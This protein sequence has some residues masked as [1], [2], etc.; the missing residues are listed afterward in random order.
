MNLNICHLVGRVTKQ[1]ES[2]A[3]PSGTTVVKFGLA[4]NHTFKD[5]NG[6]QQKTAQFHNLVAFGKVAEIIA[7]FVVKGQE[8]YVEGRIEYRS[9]DKQDGSKGYATEIMVNNFQFGQ[10][11]QGTPTGQQGQD[12][13]SQPEQPEGEE[14]IRAEDI[15]F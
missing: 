10:K 12:D 14:E 2:K 4:T 15:P 7:Q 5:K 8:L 13:Y 1:P 3:L 9:W 6:T 11:A